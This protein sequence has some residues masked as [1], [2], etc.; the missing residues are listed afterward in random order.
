MTELN[1]CFGFEI[2]R[3]YIVT[4]NAVNL[5]FNNG[6]TQNFDSRKALIPAIGFG[7]TA[8]YSD[9]HKALRKLSPFRDT[10]RNL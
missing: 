9:F 10:P 7:F 5:P 3:Y 2:I 6:K 1:P 8:G 4:Y